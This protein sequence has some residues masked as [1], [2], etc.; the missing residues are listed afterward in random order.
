[1]SDEQDI[2]IMLA[3]AANITERTLDRFAGDHW[4][5]AETDYAR[6][7]IADLAAV[8]GSATPSGDDR[9]AWTQDHNGEWHEAGPVTPTEEEPAI[10]TYGYGVHGRRAWAGNLAQL[11]AEL[12]I[13]RGLLDRYKAAVGPL[14]TVE[15]EAGS[16][17]P[18]ED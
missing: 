14:N 13:A 9:V 18:T 1:M 4:G 8:A 2:K 7:L 10:A 11:Q 17:T 3:R 16:V 15:A 5:P 12:A 6:K